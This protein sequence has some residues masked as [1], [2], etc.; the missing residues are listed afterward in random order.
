MRHS[1]YARELIAKAK[2]AVEDNFGL[3][4][5]QSGKVVKNDTTDWTERPRII[6]RELIA[7]AKTAVE[8]NFAALEKRYGKIVKTDN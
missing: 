6:A 3:L 4:E 7:K 1:K 2:M 8:G 5:N